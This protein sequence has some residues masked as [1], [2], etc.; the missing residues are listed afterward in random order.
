MVDRNAMGGIEP[1]H[2]PFGS[3]QWYRGFS[4]HIPSW[5]EYCPRLQ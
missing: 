2:A 3:W 4:P 1:P 5:T